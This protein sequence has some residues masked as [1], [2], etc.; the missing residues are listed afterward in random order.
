ME[1]VTGEAV[2]QGELTVEMA[3]GPRVVRLI[4][5][6]RTELMEFFDKTGR[7]GPLFVPQRGMPL[8]RSNAP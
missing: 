7:A 5:P 2:R 4:K 3:D 8:N 6:L 1:L